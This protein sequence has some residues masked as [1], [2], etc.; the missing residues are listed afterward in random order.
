MEW[1]LNDEPLMTVDETRR[2]F[3]DV[4]L[5]LEYRTSSSGQRWASYGA[6]SM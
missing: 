2:V 3:R 5:G 4:V 6:D 1:T